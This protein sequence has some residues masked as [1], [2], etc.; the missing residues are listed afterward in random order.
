MNLCDPSYSFVPPLLCD[1]CESSNHDVHTCS[2][3]DYVDATWASAE[4]MLNEMTS[5]I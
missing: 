5:Q 4:K 2:Y 3:G 1:Y